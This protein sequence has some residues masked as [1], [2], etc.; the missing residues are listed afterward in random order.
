MTYER[1]IK[2]ILLFAAIP[3]VNWSQCIALTF[4][5]I[6]QNWILCRDVSILSW[7]VWTVFA[8][9]I[10]KK[11]FNFFFQ[12][13]HL[14]EEERGLKW[15]NVQSIAFEGRWAGL[16]VLQSADLLSQHHQLSLGFTENGSVEEKCMLHCCSRGN[17]LKNTE[18]NFNN[19]QLGPNSAEN[20][21]WTHDTIT[22]KVQ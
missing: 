2:G 3:F 13:E 16:S 7:K 21:L 9:V 19:H 20:H 11:W 10:K 17:C 15:Q 12:T 5:I 14:N 1:L 4:P 6:T 8:A 22:N 18:R